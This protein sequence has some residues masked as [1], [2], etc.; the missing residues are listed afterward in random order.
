M[1]RALVTCAEEMESSA[2]A[3]KVEDAVE[4]EGDPSFRPA[5]VGDAR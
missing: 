4:A 2:D 3:S 5:R 1:A